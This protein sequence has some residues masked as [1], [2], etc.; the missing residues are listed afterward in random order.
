MRQVE[1]M[2]DLIG[3][4]VNTID[5]PALVL[6]LDAMERNLQTMAAFAAQHH[7]MLRPH[8]KMHK[9]A[10]LAKVVPRHS[11]G[12]LANMEGRYCLTMSKVRTGIFPMET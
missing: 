5:T 12:I 8:A 4:S 10:E 6:D 1:H 2:N 9:S 3:H 7:V 11:Y